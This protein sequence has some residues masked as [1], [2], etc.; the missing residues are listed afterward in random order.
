MQQA[1]PPEACSGREQ[2]RHAQRELEA[3]GLAGPLPH[4]LSA[5]P[6]GGQEGCPCCPKPSPTL[7]ATRRLLGSQDRE[8]LYQAVMAPGRCPPRLPPSS[9][10]AHGDHG[11]CVPAPRWTVLTGHRALGSLAASSTHCPHARAWPAGPGGSSAALAT[12][13]STQPVPGWPGPPQAPS[14]GH[15]PGT[16]PSLK[17]FPR[18][19]LDCHAG[20]SSVSLPGASPQRGGLCRVVPVP[21]VPCRWAAWSP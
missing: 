9:G 20:P 13:H 16:C 15:W 8:P 11:L 19:P 5:A 3:A 14:E 7:M 21:A 6:Q 17:P 12:C 2:P 10:T 1:R 4:E 18:R